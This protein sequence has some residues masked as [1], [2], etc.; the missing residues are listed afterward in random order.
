MREV[1]TI[2]KR[3]GLFLSP[4]TFLK[5]ICFFQKAGEDK[6]GVKNMGLDFRGKIL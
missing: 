1:Q 5:K 6:G 4:L 2:N 3:S